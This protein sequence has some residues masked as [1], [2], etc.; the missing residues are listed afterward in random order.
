MTYLLRRSNKLNQKAH[1]TDQQIQQSVGI[2]NHLKKS[3]AFLY[4]NHKST[5]KEIQKTFP[6]KISPKTIKYLGIS[7][8]KEV[9]DLYKEN[10]KTLKR[11]IE[12]LRR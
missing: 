4:A 3:E 8:T 9:K 1:R 10:Y 12:D 5:E 7:L 2:Q 6:L 11:E